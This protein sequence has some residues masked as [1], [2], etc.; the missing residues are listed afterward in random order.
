MGPGAFAAR[1][2]ARYHAARR[3]GHL[4]L[5]SPGRSGPPLSQE[6]LLADLGWRAHDYRLLRL[7]GPA[8]GRPP[9]PRSSAGPGL[10]CPMRMEADPQGGVFITDT[11][12]PGRLAPRVLHWD[13]ATGDMQVLAEGIRAMDLRLCPDTGRL[14]L[15]VEPSPGSPEFSLVIMDRDGTVRA[16]HPLFRPEY[17]RAAWVMRVLPGGGQVLAISY[18]ASRLIAYHPETLRPLREQRHFLAGLGYDLVRRPGGVIIPAGDLDC[19]L[20]VDPDSLGLEVLARPGLCGLTT[21]EP[22]PDGRWVGVHSGFLDPPPARLSIL[23]PDFTP[24]RILPLD[25]VWPIC[26]RVFQDRDGPALALSDPSG[27]IRVYALPL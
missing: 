4:V 13:P 20:A 24:E 12:D 7:N 11:G 27:G 8:P 1:G 18:A 9:V 6:R 16:E 15:L 25:A 10:F 22:L 19:L 5:A 14:L 21:L 26:V 3:L 2:L 23:R 17:G